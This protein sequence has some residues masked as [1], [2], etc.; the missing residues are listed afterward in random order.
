VASQRRDRASCAIFEG[1]FQCAKVGFH[2]FAPGTD[3]GRLR[4]TCVIAVLLKRRNARRRRA[5]IPPEKDQFT[6][7]GLF[8]IQLSSITRTPRRVRD[9]K[10]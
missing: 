2:D 9:A 1:R 10:K 5:R 4:P 3:L 6:I 8:L 7:E